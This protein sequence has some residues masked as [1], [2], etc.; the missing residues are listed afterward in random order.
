M[1]NSW[2]KDIPTRYY[3]NVL[4]LTSYLSIFL[5]SRELLFL[6]SDKH[7]AFNSLVCITMCDNSEVRC[8]RLGSCVA[9]M[10]QIND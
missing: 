8:C 9:N 3:M 10:L 4:Q 5:Q 1:I 7:D 2:T 6:I